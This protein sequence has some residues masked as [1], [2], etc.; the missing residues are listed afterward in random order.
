MAPPKFPL[1]FRDA[2]ADDIGAMS[3]LRLAVTENVLS[4]PA[5]VTPQMYRD[6][7]GT[8]GRAWVCE[9]DG[10]VVGFCYAVAADGSIWALFVD[11]AFEGLG[12]ATTLLDTACEWLSDIGKHGATLSTTAGTRADRF[13]TARGW[14]RA[15]PDQKGNVG[16]TR[17][18]S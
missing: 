7:M 17:R 1:L 4:D 9:A 15:E 3:A 18:I 13:Y 16:F 11:A 6:Y 12:I 8:L 5:K 2:Q 10:K 14:E